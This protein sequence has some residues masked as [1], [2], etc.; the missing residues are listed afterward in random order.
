[1][2]HN[3]N[4]ALSLHIALVGYG[5]V[6]KILAAELTARGATISF[7]D[8]LLADANAGAAST[9]QRQDWMAD[10]VAA[11]TVAK[12]GKSWRKVADAINAKTSG[13]A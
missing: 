11:G 4:P 8:I 12:S 7:F 13:S 6:G 10:L 9:A 1:M 2:T 3:D 5:E